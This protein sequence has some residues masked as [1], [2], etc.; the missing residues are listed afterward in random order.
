MPLG[1]V[2]WNHKNN[3][4]SSNAQ[5]VIVTRLIVNT[6]IVMYPFNT[7]L[8]QLGKIHGLSMSYIIYM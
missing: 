7:S 1:S 4:I 8:Y 3:N 5:L 6:Y 2:N